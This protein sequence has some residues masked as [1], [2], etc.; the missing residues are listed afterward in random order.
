MAR[1]VTLGEL[2]H[3]LT[4]QVVPVFA[5]SGCQSVVAGTA[6]LIAPGIAITAQHVIEEIYEQFN[7]DNASENTNLDLYVFQIVTG[8]CWYVCSVS[9]WVGT[10]IAVLSIRPRNEEASNSTVHRLKLTVDPPSIGDTVTAIGYPKSSLDIPRNDSELLHLNLTL[11]PTVS[12]GC[13]LDVHSSYRDSANVRFPSFSV[14]TEYVGG[15]SGGPVFNE[16]AQICGL[17]CAGGKGELAD[18]S[19]ATSVWPVCIISALVPEGVPKH[20]GVVSGSSYK[21]LE[22]ARHGYI[23]LIGHERIEFFTYENGSL[24]VRRRHR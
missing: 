12:E 22:L 11:L 20:E 24:G 18:Y 6:I 10:D 23:D 14:E 7:V 17:V 2:Q 21:I 1:L 15:M 19:V 13:V 5:F 3:R 8:A 9:H 16:N 4:L